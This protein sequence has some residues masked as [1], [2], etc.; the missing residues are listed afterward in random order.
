MNKFNSA[1]YQQSFTHLTL[2][3][4]LNA[5]PLEKF[6]KKPVIYLVFKVIKN[7]EDFVLIYNYILYEK[8]FTNSLITYLII[9]NNFA[10]SETFME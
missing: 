10:K 8:I 3:H 5:G 9:K 2:H 1:L 6:S 7:R 4:I